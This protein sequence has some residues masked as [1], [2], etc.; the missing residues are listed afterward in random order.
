MYNGQI[1]WMISHTGQEERWSQAIRPMC[2]ICRKSFLG[3]FI[4]SSQGN[5][6]SLLILSNTLPSLTKRDEGKLTCLN[7][8]YYHP[9]LSSMQC[10][11][12]PWG[13]IQSFCFPLLLIRPSSRYEI[14][15]GLFTY[16]GS[17]SDQ[18]QMTA[19]SMTWKFKHCK[20]GISPNHKQLKYCLNRSND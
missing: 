20:T 7:L 6:F 13:L 5:I 14:C 8:F 9:A 11:E 18:L 10:L 1:S 16:F 2:S 4:F 3:I 15:T 12:I 17:Q 19:K